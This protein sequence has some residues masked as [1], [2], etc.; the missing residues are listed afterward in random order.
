MRSWL[1]L[2]AASALIA[3]A[4]P[5]AAAAADY[6]PGQVIV[7]YRDGTSRTVRSDVQQETGTDS[8]RRLPS[9]SRQLE[10][11]DGDTVGETVRELERDPNVGYA[12][13]NYVARATALYPNDPAFPR[14]WNFAGPFGI[15][16]PEAWS[17]ARRLGAPGGR[18][19]VVALLDTG[20]AYRNFRGRRR[21]M[22][23]PD[24]GR[25]VPGRDFIDGDRYPFDLNGHGTH[26]AG[27]IAQATNN[28]R[29]TAGIA[30]RARIMPIRVLD[31]EGTGDTVAISR[32]IRYAV[33]RR[34]KIINLSLEFGTSVRAAEIPDV[35]SALRF[36]RRRGVVVVAASGN[37][38]EG[39]IAYPARSRYTIAVGATTARGCQ[40]EYS[41]GGTGLDLVAP[42]GGTD[43]PNGDNPWDQARCRPD[44]RGRFILQQ[45]FT[46][47]IRRFGLP[48]GYEGTSMAASHATGVVA[49]LLATRRLGRGTPP[50]AVEAHLEATARDGGRPGWDP[51]YGAG[52]LD[53]AAALR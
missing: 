18:G 15:G 4:A 7:K 47:S 24:L 1:L 25:F 2:P 9:G 21:Y 32:A 29:S 14:Q 20:V 34:V 42:G 30:Y 52:L 36:A 49:L 17:S 3:L 39:R 26:V 10:I 44:R 41:N 48:S 19:A 33:R 23:A 38:G 51:R 40:A 6:V 43:A 53:A 16:M 12:V 8:A 35:L 31:S 45:T 5:G 37:Q 11:E 50:S 27:T 13:P 46:S 22:K 28:R